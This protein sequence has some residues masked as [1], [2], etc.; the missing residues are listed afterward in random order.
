MTSSSRNILTCAYNRR[1]R[2]RSHMRV[3]PNDIDESTIQTSKPKLPGVMMKTTS[4][5]KL[6][7]LSE[8]DSLP[9]PSLTSAS[10]ESTE[11][12]TSSSRPQSIFRRQ[13]ADSIDAEA[14]DDDMLMLKRANPVYDSDDEDDLIFSP[15]KRQRTGESTSIL[16]FCDRIDEDDAKGLFSISESAF[17]PH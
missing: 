3:M 17:L 7:I 6:T 16:S 5:S 4:Q 8:N 12:S 9:V 2:S 13:R 10:M 11:S 14:N 1:R 15:A